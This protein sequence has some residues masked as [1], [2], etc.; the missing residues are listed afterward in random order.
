VQNVYVTALRVLVVA[1]Q[2]VGSPRL[3]A[4]LAERKAAGATFHVVVPVTGR[5]ELERLA[6]LCCD[7]LG[8][9]M[10]V[11]PE[12]A[13]EE[14]PDDR[15]QQRLRAQLAQLAEIGATATGE[16]GDEDPVTAVRDA[17]KRWP[18]DEVLLSTLPSGLSKWLALDLPHRLA[19]K[20]T[21][22]IT[23]VEATPE[24]APAR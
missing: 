5:S 9:P 15:A 3:R 17:L 19:R 16:I 13:D 12:I 23:T 14:T 21:T 20:C 1:N 24:T 8:G 10:A 18:A 7:P 11:I 2:T 4:A 6:A 22:P